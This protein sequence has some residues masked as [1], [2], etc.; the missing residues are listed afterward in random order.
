MAKESGVNHGEPSWFA[1]F[2]PLLQWAPQY[3]RQWLRPDLIAGLTVAALVVSKSLGYAGIAGVPPEIGLYVATVP[4]IVYA[5]VGSSRRMTVGPSATGAAV[6]AA[7][8]APIAAE[9]DE[10]EVGTVDP[11]SAE[12]GSAEVSFTDLLR[13]EALGKGLVLLQHL[14]VAENVVDRRA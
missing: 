11:C 3:E 12:I 7:A 1:R 14:A 2:I 5:L 6:S 8:I 13:C 4:L 10:V 9:I